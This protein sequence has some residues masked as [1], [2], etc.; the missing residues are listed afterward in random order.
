M[1]LTLVHEKHQKF[2]EPLENQTMCETLY[3]TKIWE[4]WKFIKEAK[5]F[6][7]CET[8]K[9]LVVILAPIDLIALTLY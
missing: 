4:V 1:F 7:L 5:M 9:I 3:E 2:Y 6:Y 8:I